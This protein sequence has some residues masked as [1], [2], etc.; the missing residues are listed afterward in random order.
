MLLPRDGFVDDSRKERQKKVTNWILELE[1][2][3]A[4]SSILKELFLQ[5]CM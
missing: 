2:E 4:E 1:I 3:G 5:Y